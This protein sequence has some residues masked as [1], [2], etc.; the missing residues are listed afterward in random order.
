MGACFFNPLLVFFFFLLVFL[1]FII[2][3]FINIPSIVYYLLFIFWVYFVFLVLGF[4]GGGCVKIKIEI[5]ELLQCIMHVR[6]DNGKDSSKQ[7]ID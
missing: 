4:D 2:I 6:S 3:F 1:L 5:K 7:M